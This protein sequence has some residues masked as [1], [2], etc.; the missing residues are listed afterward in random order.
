MEALVAPSS[1]MFFLMNST[2]VVGAGGDGISRCA[3]EPI[4]DRA[5]HNQYQAG[6]WGSQDRDPGGD[7]GPADLLGQQDKDGEYHRCG[8]PTTAVPISTGFAVR[9]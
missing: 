1:L 5:A 6:T 7:I 9:A 3:G 2:A 8:Q 4:D